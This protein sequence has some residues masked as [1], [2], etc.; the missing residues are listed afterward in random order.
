MQ[1]DSVGTALRCQRWCRHHID[2]VRGRLAN[3]APD[4]VADGEAEMVVTFVVVCGRVNHIGRRAG[5]VSVRR[6]GGDGVGD[7]ATVER[8]L[9]RQPQTQR[10]VRARQDGLTVRTEVRVA[11][12]D[13]HLSRGC[14]TAAVAPPDNPTGGTRSLGFCSRGGEDETTKH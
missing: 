1:D 10:L 5:Q 6:P 13:V 2:R 7:I 11:Y 14:P 8:T 4:A 3:R 9:S 12:D